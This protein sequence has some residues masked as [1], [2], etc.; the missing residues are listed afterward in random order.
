M[1]GRTASATGVSGSG[2]LVSGS[3]EAR[4]NLDVGI[5]LTWKLGA[6]FEPLGLSAKIVSIQRVAGLVS[7]GD[8]RPPIVSDSFETFFSVSST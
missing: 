2:L 7:H 1:T 8:F 4:E 3:G 6:D 5:S